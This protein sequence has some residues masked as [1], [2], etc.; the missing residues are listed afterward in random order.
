MSAWTV[1][2]ADALQDLAARL[3]PRLAVYPAVLLLG[4]LGAGKTTFVQGLFRALGVTEVVK[5]PTFDLV[6]PYRGADGRPLYH[7]DLFRLAEPPPPA[8]LDVDDPAG[9]VAVEWGAP[10]RPYYPTRAEITLQILPSGARTI[11]VEEIEAA[12]GEG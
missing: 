11:R 3:A 7:V 1:A 6:H 12:G 5:S 4:E 9:L 10:W 2:T 8:A